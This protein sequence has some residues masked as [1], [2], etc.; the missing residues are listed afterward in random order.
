MVDSPTRS[1][2]CAYIYFKTEVKTLLAKFM[3]SSIWNELLVNTRDLFD[4]IWQYE[5][6][7]RQRDALKRL[8]S[9]QRANVDHSALLSLQRSGMVVDAPEGFKPFSPMF[10]QFLKICVQDIPS[11]LSDDGSSEIDGLTIWPAKRSIQYNEEPPVHLSITEWQLFILL[12][13][14]IQPRSLKK[15]MKVLNATDK[16]SGAS[17]VHTTLYRLRNKIN[18][19]KLITS[20]HGDGYRLS[21]TK[22]EAKHNQSHR[23]DR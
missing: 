11:K 1:D 15:L 12:W 2:G 18:N 14:N 3:K 4:D 23:E 13:E 21:T 20:V 8:A 9:G 10:E 6:T 16:K 19:R 22:M 5:L 7:D 17:V